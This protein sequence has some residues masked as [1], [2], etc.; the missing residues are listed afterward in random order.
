MK[1]IFE[2]INHVKARPHHIRKQ[3][4][5]ASAAVGTILI[6]LVWLVGSATTG[7]FSIKGDSF[8]TSA[9]QESTVTTGSNASG[10]AGVGAAAALP[11]AKA[12]AR[13]EI[14]DATPAAGA[15]K[16]AEQTTIPF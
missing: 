12:P 3:V 8:A 9:E 10:L 14:I 1:T 13:I 6:A 11:D 16:Q 2:H 4:A 5:F 7:A 15:Q